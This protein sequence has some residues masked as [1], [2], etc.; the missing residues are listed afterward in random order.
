MQTTLSSTCLVVVVVVE[1]ILLSF[2]GEKGN[3]KKK[4]ETKAR[5][6]QLTSPTDF[7]SVSDVTKNLYIIED[8]NTYALEIV[9]ELPPRTT[10][11]C[12]IHQRSTPKD[13]PRLFDHCDNRLTKQTL[14]VYTTMLVPSL[15]AAAL[16]FSQAEAFVVAPSGSVARSVHLN[17]E[18]RGPTD[19]SDVLR[20]VSV[21]HYF[22]RCFFVVVLLIQL[23][24]EMAG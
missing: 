5:L 21:V 13:L 11:V 19:K 3:P 15:V 2:N 4:C 12:S 16:I 10:A 1:A 20:C 8:N 7:P 24:F 18:I 22:F 9:E 17:A 23:S 6:Q 14:F